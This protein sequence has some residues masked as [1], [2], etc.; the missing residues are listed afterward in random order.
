MIATSWVE[1]NYGVFFKNRIGSGEPTH[2]NFL[3]R[4]RSQGS[5]K[6]STMG[7]PIVIYLLKLKH[8]KVAN[9]SKSKTYFWYLAFKI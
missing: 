7:T 1:N 6:K 3:K 4:T 9:L 2:I 8:R 5:E